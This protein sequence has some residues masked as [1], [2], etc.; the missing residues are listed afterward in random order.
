MKKLE[1]KQNTKS[2]KY[3]LLIILVIS[4]LGTI[5]FGI[6][7]Y[8]NSISH[9]LK[10]Q[11]ILA[12]P[13]IIDSNEFNEP[14]TQIDKSFNNKISEHPVTDKNIDIQDDIEQRIEPIKYLRIYLINVNHLVANFLQDKKYTNELTQITKLKLPE[15]IDQTISD[16]SN[17]NDNYLITNDITH[18]RIFPTDSKFI[19]KFI[20][21]EKATVNLSDKA[22]LRSKI[23]NKLDD[24]IDFFYSDEFH[25]IFI[26]GVK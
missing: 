5:G 10:E 12:K 16:L 6:Y 3:F 17:Y 15:Q 8:Y 13:V 18:R 14:K 20:K 4:M 9:D 21:I 26:K 19:E 7:Y 22:L 23:I 11:N 24:F 2:A 25:N 1:Q